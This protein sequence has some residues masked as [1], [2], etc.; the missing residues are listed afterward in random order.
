MVLLVLSIARAWDPSL[1]LE[2]TRCPPSKIHGLLITS[3]LKD[4]YEE[5]PRCRPIESVSQ[6]YAISHEP[7]FKLSSRGSIFSKEWARDSSGNFFEN[8]VKLGSL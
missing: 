3:T 1:F 2:K 4:S 6:L 7:L 8:G 5:N